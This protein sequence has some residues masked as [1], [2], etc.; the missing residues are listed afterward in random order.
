MWVRD[1]ENATSPNTFSCRWRTSVPNRWWRGIFSSILLWDLHI[2]LSHILFSMIYSLPQDHSRECLAYLSSKQIPHFHQHLVDDEKV[3]GYSNH[4]E[5]V[6]PMFFVIVAISPLRTASNQIPNFLKTAISSPLLY[7][8][9]FEKAPHQINPF[10]VVTSR[11]GSPYD[12]L[13]L[14]YLD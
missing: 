12:A 10:A 2:C 14:N 1:A 8:V 5:S 6:Y 11:S 4:I 9:S 7:S 13:R 3:H